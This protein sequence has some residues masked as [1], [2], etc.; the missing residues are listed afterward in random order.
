MIK[1]V[2]KFIVKVSKISNFT[3]FIKRVFAKKS[4]YEE[5][6]L[7]KGNWSFGEIFIIAYI[8]FNYRTS[9]EDLIEYVSICLKRKKSTVIRKISTLRGIK[10]GKA[11]NASNLDISVVLNYDSKSGGERFYKF[12]KM[13]Q[14]LDSPEVSLGILD[15]LLLN[16]NKNKK[17]IFDKT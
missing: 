6:V 14:E 4:Q 7:K 3:I 5:I 10:N 17:V 11:N 13:L 16:S 15:N 1:I 2:K 12:C 8:G 9:N